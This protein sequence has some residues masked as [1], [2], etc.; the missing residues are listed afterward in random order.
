M[1]E[2]TFSLKGINLNDP[3]AV[4]L[5]AKRV[6]IEEFVRRVEKGTLTIDIRWLKED[7]MEA[8]IKQAPFYA[9]GS[10]TDISTLPLQPFSTNNMN[11]NTIIEKWAGK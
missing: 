11:I 8:S 6:L 7:L 2:A 9:R 4:K 5:A 1:I 3:N 10:I